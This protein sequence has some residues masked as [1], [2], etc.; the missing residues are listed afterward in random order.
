MERYL[1]VHKVS[2]TVIKIL[3]LSI[4]ATIE[5]VLIDLRLADA[6]GDPQTLK[7]IPTQPYA[8]NSRSYCRQHPD[9]CS[10]PGPL[11]GAAFGPQRQPPCLGVPTASY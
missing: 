3:F 10:R 9:Y 4:K 5:I 2:P 7:S 11:G 1:H 6:A 8:G